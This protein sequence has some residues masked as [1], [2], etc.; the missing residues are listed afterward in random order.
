[1][2]RMLALM[3]GFPVAIAEI[4]CAQSGAA[5][6]AK[7]NARHLPSTHGVNYYIA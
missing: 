1:M 6:V 7:G 3:C 2:D 4:V 5:N